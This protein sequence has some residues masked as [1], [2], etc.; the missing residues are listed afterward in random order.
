MV[1][2]LSLGL[3]LAGSPDLD[4]VP[5]KSGAFIV[6]QG[7]VAGAPG[8]IAFLTPD[9][10]G[11]TAALLCP[12]ADAARWRAW[13]G[14]FAAIGAESLPTRLVAPDEGACAST[15]AYGADEK[16][17]NVV[18]FAVRRDGAPNG[19]F[20]TSIGRREAD[21]LA[22]RAQRF[23]EA[24]ATAAVMADDSAAEPALRLLYLAR[25]WSLRPDDP[26]WV[27]D[28]AAARSVAAR[29][30]DVAAMLHRV[31]SD[32]RLRPGALADLAH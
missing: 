30:G 13:S 9:E 11:E 8:R 12:V 16:T 19:A 27:A 18:Q 25:G 1:L 14:Y 3:A 7:P 22:A 24:V 26:G 6:F 32:K 15:A 23:S 17:R 4:L 10:V 28:L 21:L 5:L 20:S 31:W 29:G 2:A